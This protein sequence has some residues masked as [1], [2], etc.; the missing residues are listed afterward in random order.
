MSMRDLFL[1]E[2]QMAVRGFQNENLS[3]LT[4]M[5]LS[6]MALRKIITT[7]EAMEIIGI[8]SSHIIKGEDYVD[9]RSN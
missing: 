6:E 2:M 1:H 3:V 8:L 5:C 4:G 7:Q 9:P